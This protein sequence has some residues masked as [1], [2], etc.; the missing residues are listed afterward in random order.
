MAFQNEKLFDDEAVS[1]LQIQS[2][3]LESHRLSSGGPRVFVPPTKQTFIGRYDTTQ[4]GKGPVVN[5]DAIGFEIQFE[6]QGA[7]EVEIMLEQ[8]ISGPGGW[9]EDLG[10]RSLSQGWDF[11]GVTQLMSEPGS[12]PHHFMVYVDGV[13]QRTPLR[14]VQA[15][16]I[17]TFDTADAVPGEVLPYPVATGLDPSKSYSIRI[18]KTSEPELC[19]QYL[20]PNW[21]SFSGLMLDSG[22]VVQPVKSHP[23]HRIEFIGDSWMAGFANVC[24]GTY[25]EVELG[26]MGGEESKD[27]TRWGSYALSWPFIGC[28]ILGAECHSTILSGIGVYCNT[29][30]EHQAFDCLSEDRL[31][32]FWQRTLV[33]QKTSR[34]NKSLWTPDVV[35]IPASAN[36]HMFDPLRSEP[37]AVNTYAEFIQE[38]ASTYTDAKII[39]TC[40]PFGHKVAEYIGGPECAVAEKAVHGQKKSGVEV[41]FLSLMDFARDASLGQCSGHADEEYSKLVGEHFAAWLQDLL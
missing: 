20:T 18:V 2:R 8:T 36:D 30:P 22:E 16:R 9:F 27:I 5:F 29:H 28:E 14:P 10:S 32:Q 15:C 7:T 41:H 35:V 3:P 21:L 33:T 19:V 13:Q 12:Q 26:P 37:Q 23:Q 39:I 17:C 34:W 31:P 1:L 40:G 4:S 24:N 6:V 38:V 25:D 11:T